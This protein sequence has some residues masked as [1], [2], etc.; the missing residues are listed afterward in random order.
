MKMVNVRIRKWASAGRPAIVADAKVKN[1][2][3]ISRP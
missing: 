1:A 3:S 2:E